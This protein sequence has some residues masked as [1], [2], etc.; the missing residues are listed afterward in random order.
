MLRA[1][2]NFI[3]FFGHDKTKQKT[4]LAYEGSRNI[5]NGVPPITSLFTKL[6]YFFSIQPQYEPPLSWDCSY[7][8]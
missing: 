5:I 7:P 3:S 2:N 4:S 6:Q 1:V 8:I